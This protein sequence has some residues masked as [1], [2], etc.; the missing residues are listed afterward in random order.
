MH[1][2]AYMHNIKYMDIGL[3][4]PLKVRSYTMKVPLNIS[5]DTRTYLHVYLMEEVAYLL[6]VLRIDAFQPDQFQ[7]K[8]L[9]KGYAIL[10]Y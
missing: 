1:T 4:V 5:I 6:H 9:R 8:K 2:H 7:S 3:S 10:L